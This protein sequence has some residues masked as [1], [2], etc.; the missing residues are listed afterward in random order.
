MER[1]RLH[2][3]EEQLSVHCSVG[4]NAVGEMGEQEQSEGGKA[5]AVSAPK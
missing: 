1:G 5:A 2:V 3:C 4:T